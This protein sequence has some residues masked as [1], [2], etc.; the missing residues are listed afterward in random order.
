[1]L[2]AALGLCNIRAR[3]SRKAIGKTVALLDGALIP[4]VIG[5]LLIIA[6]TGKTLSTI[7]CYIY[8]LGMDLAIYALLRFAFDYCQIGADKRKYLL[9]AYIPM[10]AD[11]AQML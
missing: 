5:N 4:P 6:S 3:R 1:M 9:F 2:I 10:A 8:F 7:G 11:V